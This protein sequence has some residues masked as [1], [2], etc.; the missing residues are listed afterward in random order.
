[1][2]EEPTWHPGLGESLAGYDV[3]NDILFRL[4][5]SLTN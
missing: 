4:S 3:F 2:L 5:I 1:M